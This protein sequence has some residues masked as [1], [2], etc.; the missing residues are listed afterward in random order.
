VAQAFKC[1]LKS[2]GWHYGDD[3]RRRRPRVNKSLPAGNQICPARPAG[4]RAAA[5][6]DK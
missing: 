5:G 4:A 3:D 1:N 2:A 6:G